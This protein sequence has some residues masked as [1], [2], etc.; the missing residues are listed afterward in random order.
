[1]INTSELENINGSF[2]FTTN[3]LLYFSSDTNECKTMAKSTG[4]EEGKDALCIF[5]FLF[6]GTN[7]SECIFELNEYNAWCPTKVDEIGHHLNGGNYWGFCQESCPIIGQKMKMIRIKSLNLEFYFSLSQGWKIYL[8]YI[9][10]VSEPECQQNSDCKNES[11]PFCS[12]TTC[13]GE[14]N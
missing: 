8:H 7:Y 5:P 9:F 6:K 11:L 1:M 14:S 13:L 10:I 12:G 4:P 3:I 2:I